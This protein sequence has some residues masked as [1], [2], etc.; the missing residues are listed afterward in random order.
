MPPMNRKRRGASPATTRKLSAAEQADAARE[1]ALD[2]PVAEMD[3]PVRVINTLERRGALLCR[4][5]MN[6]SDFTISTT[7]N[8]GEKG[9]NLLKNAIS[10]LGLEPPNWTVMAR[11]TRGNTGS[12]HIVDFPS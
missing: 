10:K 2:T 4:D 6:L 3:L 11:K 8:L 5:L 1:Q 7:R 12:H 9:V